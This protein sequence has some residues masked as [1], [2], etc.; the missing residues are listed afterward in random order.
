MYLQYLSDGWLFQF[1][2]YLLGLLRDYTYT[3]VAMHCM[4]EEFGNAS[5]IDHE[6]GEFHRNGQ[7][8]LPC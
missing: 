4:T 5:S 7:S 6:W 3:R 8:S 2:T 1:K